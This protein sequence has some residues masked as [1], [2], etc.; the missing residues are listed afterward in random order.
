ML[1]VDNALR[2]AGSGLKF[3]LK[4]Q[5]EL[6]ELDPASWPIFTIA[7]DQ[8]TD[9]WC[10]AYWLLYLVFACVVVVFDPSHRV[11]NDCQLALADA[12]LTGIVALLV[13]VFNLDHGP[14]QDL[15]SPTHIHISMC[16]MNSIAYMLADVTACPNKQ[17]TCAHV[18]IQHC[19]RVSFS[20]VATV[21]NDPMFED[22][23]H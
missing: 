15:A 21:H 1:A 5:K 2:G 4:P 20:S 23:R 19:S 16:A 17:T 9:G 3:V 22:M 12:H 14:W 10:A 7:I 6:D 11:W 13:V 18:Y 8:G